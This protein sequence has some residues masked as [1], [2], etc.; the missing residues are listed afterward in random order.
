LSVD[1]PFCCVVLLIDSFFMG[2]FSISNNVNSVSKLPTFSKWTAEYIFNYDIIYDDFSMIVF[3]TSRISS[4]HIL[5]TDKFWSLFVYVCCVMTF[6]M[7][8]I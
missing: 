1:P 5:C 7:L 2:P 3:S 4:R 8:S 6:K